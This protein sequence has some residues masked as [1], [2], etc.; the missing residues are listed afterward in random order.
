MRVVMGGMNRVRLLNLMLESA[1]KCSRVTAAVAY[2]TQSDPFFEH[3]QAQAT[4][5]DFYGLLDETGAVWRPTIIL[6]AQR[7]P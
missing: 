6:S 1:G 5:V 7:Q 3:C 4:P 2:A